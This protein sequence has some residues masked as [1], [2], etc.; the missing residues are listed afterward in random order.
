MKIVLQPLAAVAAAEA[1]IYIKN[2]GSGATVLIISNKE[3]E[4]IMKVLAKQFKMKQ[5]IKRRIS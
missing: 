3:K 5:K 2:L 1:G 4:D